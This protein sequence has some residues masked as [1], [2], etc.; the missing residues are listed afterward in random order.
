MYWLFPSNGFSPS[1][2]F[3]FGRER[4]RSIIKISKSL[5]LVK[6]IG[7]PETI[8]LEG[9]YIET[10]QV[11]VKGLTTR[12]GR[13]FFDHFSALIDN[14]LA[15]EI[16]LQ[17]HPESLLINGIMADIKSSGGVRNSILTFRAD[18]V[19]S[20]YDIVQSLIGIVASRKFNDSPAGMVDEDIDIVR[21]GVANIFYDIQKDVTLPSTI[22]DYIDDLFGVCLTQMFPALVIGSRRIREIHPLIWGFLKQWN[23]LKPNANEQKLVLI[24]LLK[25]MD[26]CKSFFSLSLSEEIEFFHRAGIDKRSLLKSILSLKKMVSI[27]KKLNYIFSISEE[28]SR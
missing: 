7:Y 19:L 4:L 23:L 28:R 26:S 9:K 11:E 3:L 5:F 18:Y 2:H 20:I 6:K 1:T 27:Y 21:E 12:K 10:R 14:E 8:L 16:M 15:N 25:V 24:N 22:S 17:E 13:Y